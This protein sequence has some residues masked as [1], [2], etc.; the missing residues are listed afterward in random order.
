[1]SLNGERFGTRAGTI[2]LIAFYLALWPNGSQARRPQ[3][4][5]GDVVYVGV[6]EDDRRQLDRL[7]P[8]DSIPVSGRTI[9]PLFEKDQSGWKPVRDRDLSQRITWSVVFDGKNLGTIDSEPIPRAILGNVTGPTN[10]HS[11][12]TPAKEIPV[13]GKPGGRFSGSSGKLVRRPLVVVSKP[14]FSD[15][16]EWK[17]SAIPNGILE[18][19]RT[20]FR[21]TFRHIR[22]CN[23]AGEAL[24]DDWSIPASEIVVSKSYGSTKHEYIVETHVLH[25]KCLFNVYGGDFQ[26]MGGNQVFFASPDH[27]A[28]LLGLQWELLDAGD[29]DGEGR[30]EVIFQ[31][32]EGKDIDIETEGYVLFY[33]DFQHNARFTWT[34]H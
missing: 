18:E 2:T 26:S 27:K 13:V 16:D 32:A 22:Q 4:Q 21:T 34:N 28:V 11:I 29:Y 14:N 12:L 10:I 7:G 17:P 19:V 15:P 9:T 25:S 31:V 20:T 5:S 8:K 1:M 6:I 24:K 23:A 3:T 30:S 33:D